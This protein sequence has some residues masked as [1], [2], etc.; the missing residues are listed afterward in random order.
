M[1]YK[2]N[3]LFL[4][5]ILSLLKFTILIQYK[6][7]LFREICQKLFRGC[8]HLHS[9][10]TGL[11]GIERIILIR[12]TA[13]TFGMTSQR[14]ISTNSNTIIIKWKI[15]TVFFL[16]IL[17]ILKRVSMNYMF[18]M[19]YSTFNLRRMFGESGVIC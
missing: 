9:V 15:S 6:I 19:H 17:F 5:T 1:L 7:I 16:Q 12:I 3:E 18:K 14:A 10:E 11:I 13:V 4:C 2:N 8:S